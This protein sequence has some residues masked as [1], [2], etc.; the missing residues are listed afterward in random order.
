MSPSLRPACGVLCVLALVA[1][2]SAAR[3]TP[4]KVLVVGEPSATLVTRLRAELRA[5]GLRVELSDSDEDPR[6][7]VLSRKADALAATSPSPPKVLLWLR[8]GEQLEPIGEL[9]SETPGDAGERVLVLR[10]VEILRAQLIPL[11]EP[12][13][14]LD[15]SSE[16]AIESA[17]SSPGPSGVERSEPAPRPASGAAQAAP[18]LETPPVDRDTAR[19]SAGA[20]PRFAFAIGGGLL[21]APGGSPPAAQLRLGV[22]WPLLERLALEAQVVAPTGGA[23]LVEPEGTIDLHLLGAAL[24]PSLWLTDPRED[25]A[26]AAHAGLGAA[27]LFHSA[28][29]SSPNVGD[30]GASPLF[31]SYVGLSA[32]YRVAPWVAARADADLWWLAPRHGF[33]T[34]GRES[35]SVGPLAMVFALGVEV[36]P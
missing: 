36:S 24:G 31:A 20:R 6:T 18:A 10:A 22:A 2:S 27:A 9:A 11:E 30:S 33:R 16:T 8:R 23:A 12:A 4:S 25:L 7:L 28:E 29:A 21:V 1:C 35:A 17:A 14:L 5:L 3:A 32:R 19:A 26:A 15:S 34:V 13:P